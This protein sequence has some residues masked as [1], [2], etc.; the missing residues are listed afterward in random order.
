MYFS[1]NKKFILIVT[2]SKNKKIM[3]FK[4]CAPL[5]K[6]NNYDFLRFLFAFIVVVKHST[7]LSGANTLNVIEPFFDTY[8]AVTGFFI[9]SGLLITN[10][11]IRTSTIKHYAKKRILRIAPAYIF[12]VITCAIFLSLLSTL[13]IA[14]YF[15]NSQLYKY[16]A[17]NLLL[18][19]FLCPSLPGVFEDSNNIIT[20]VNAS[21]WTIKIEVMFYISVPLFIMLFRRLKNDASLI[22]VCI[23]IYSLSIMYHQYFET[24]SASLDNQIPS[25]LCY[26]ISGMMLLFYSKFITSKINLLTISAIIIFALEYYLGVEYLRPIAF[27]IIIFYCSINFKFLN[28][29]SK[30]GDFSYGIYIFH[31]PII[32]VLAFYGL[33]SMSNHWLALII[34]IV[35]V[36]IAA[37][38]S[39]NC[40]EKRFLSQRKKFQ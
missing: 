16:L 32:Q 12:I 33:F 28:N 18:M 21:L 6:K 15:T 35:V 1:K 13:S 2:F 4:N 37:Y 25:F 29:F 7:F 30:H 22:I 5:D 36:M 19:N 27:A 17:S 23:I 34:I 31:F 40:I 39:W 9:I 20:V 11:F 10:S 38:F 24:R 8:V 3:D 26:F 14:E